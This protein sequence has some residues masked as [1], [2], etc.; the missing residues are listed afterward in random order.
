MRNMSVND[1][2]ERSMSM[3][4]TN[5][6]VKKS[7]D[8]IDKARYELTNTQQRLILYTIAH[9]NVSDTDFKDYDIPISELIE[10]TG[11][12]HWLY[13]ELKKE[14]QDLMKKVFTIENM[15]EDNKKVAITMAWFSSI[16]YVE[17]SGTI[18]IHFDPHLKPYLLQLKERFTT[19]MLE[20]VLPMRSSYSTRVYELLK[21]YEGFGFRYFDLEEFKKLLIINEKPVYSSYGHI[22]SYILTP[23]IHKI[24]KFTDLDIDPNIEEKKRSR[25]VI[26]FTL[27]FKKKQFIDFESTQPEEQP[28]P[29][30]APQPETQPTSQPEP[31]SQPASQPEQPD[32][33]QSELQPQLTPEPVPQPEPQQA[34]QPE[35]TSQPEEQPASQPEQL[36]DQRHARLEKL[37]SYVPKEHQTASVRDIISDNLDKYDDDYIIS[38]IEYV[39][40]KPFKDFPAYLN[41]ALEKDYA[42]KD[43]RDRE[44]L[45]REKAE[46]EEKEKKQQEFLM[47]KQQAISD[48]W[49]IT[50]QERLSRMPP[51]THKVLETQ[52]VAQ[53][54]ASYPVYNKT[55][56]PGS[57]IEAKMRE[58]VRKALESQGVKPLVEL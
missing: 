15:S 10:K 5:S 20:Y 35:P 17:G 46:Q 43:L 7:N 47:K 4:E 28:A 27:H 11:S 23:A 8:L 13:S 31:T 39:L 38:N 24:A 42:T 55:P 19:Y 9:I 44:K 50:L 32:Q 30:Q 53:I 22:K 25:K 54:K 12:S 2:N 49:E 45:A 18:Q 16:K 57:M 58:I 34:P 14:A 40:S 1:K 52:A 56:I 36:Q 48:W 21:Q 29:Q 6:I 37:R 33:P 51:E 26:G 41:T 3:N